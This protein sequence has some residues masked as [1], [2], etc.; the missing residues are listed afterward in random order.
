MNWALEGLKELL[1]DKD[2]N[3][4]LPVEER[5][6]LWRKMSNPIYAFLDD[7]IDYDK[8]AYVSKEDLYRAFLGYCDVEGFTPMSKTKFGQTFPMVCTKSWECQPRIKK[9]KKKQVTAWCG[10]ALRE[11]KS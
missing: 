5:T 2:F 7:M 1:R 10:I 9:G 11:E 6:K 8:D 4:L 3:F